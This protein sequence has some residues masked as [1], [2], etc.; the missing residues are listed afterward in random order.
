VLKLRW[1]RRSLRWVAIFIVVVLAA[2]WVGYRLWSPGLEVRDGRHDR[3]RNA[4][5]LA[6]GWLGGD[7]W[8][9]RYGKTNEFTRY[10]DLGKIRELASKL[11]RHHITDVFPHLCPA[12]PDG[13][14]P[15]VDA[16]QVERFLDVFSGFRVIPWVGGVNGTAVRMQDSRWRATFVGRLRALLLAHPRLAG[17]QLNI[18]PCPSGDPNFLKLLEELGQALPEGKLRSVAAYPPPT[19]WHPYPDV[20][21]DEAYFREVARRSE[22]FAVMMYDAAQ[23]VPKAYQQLMVDWTTEVLA[24]AEGKEVL[25]GVPTYADADVGWHDP[26]VENITNALLGIHRGLERSPMPPH[27]Q[28]VAIYSDWETDEGEWGYFRQH[29]LKSD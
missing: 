25:L 7:E 6:H 29:F 17:V 11:R 23:H 24:W 28:G 14:I 1:N 26:K 8:F 3:G 22:Q 18:E 2:S 4:I 12:T 16:D 20:H 27:Y 15:A 21:W 5:W 13:E 10:R 19:R 9:I